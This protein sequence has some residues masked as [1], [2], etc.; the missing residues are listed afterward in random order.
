MNG[1]QWRVILAPRHQEIRRDGDKA[2]ARSAPTQVQLIEKVIV[3]RSPATD[4][5]VA[6]LGDAITT[7][8][9]VLTGRRTEHYEP[10]AHAV[11]PRPVL[12]W[13]GGRG[14]QI[15][16]VAARSADGMFL[17]GCTPEQHDSIV[18]NA[19]GIEPNVG[20]ALY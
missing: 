19:R 6:V 4:K 5:P 15:V 16:A 14:P 7:A 17:S 1:G 12:I 2:G 9:A 18:T 8:R 11:A 20:L 3:S 10:P 13:V